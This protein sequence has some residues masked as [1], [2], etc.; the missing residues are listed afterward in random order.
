MDNPDLAQEID[1]ALRPKGNGSRQG[2][3]PSAQDNYGVYKHDF[4][5]VFRTG[6]MTLSKESGDLIY[7]LA[8]QLIALNITECR[9]MAYELLSTHKE[10]PRQSD[11]RPD[12]GA[13]AGI[14]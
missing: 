1:Q 7:D 3:R 8:L 14:G 13:R 10:A 4:K 6:K 11:G 5:Q 2:H 12:R 9:H